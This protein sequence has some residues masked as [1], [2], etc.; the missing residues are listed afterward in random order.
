MAELHSFVPV[1][2]AVAARVRP[3]A[4]LEWG[5]GLFTRLLADLAPNS[6]ILSIEHD[7][8]Y[9][10]LQRAQLDRPN[11]E[12]TY[13]PHLLPFGG[14]AGYVTY[15]LLWLAERGLPRRHFA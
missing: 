3:L 1:L 5:P 8:R 6:R 4:I 11:V 12:L 2:T 13:V 15:P 9:F 14:S 10:D 7:M